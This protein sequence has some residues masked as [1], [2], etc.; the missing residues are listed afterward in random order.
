MKCRK[1]AIKDWDKL[2]DEISN[3]TPSCLLRDGYKHITS[4]INSLDQSDYNAYSAFKALDD[5]L[6]TAHYCFIQGCRSDHPMEKN[7]RESQYAM[8]SHN[9]KSAVVWY[10]SARDYCLQ[11][12]FWGF[13]FNSTI[14]S[15]KKFDSEL[16][17]CFLSGNGDD[18][19]FMKD[20]HKLAKGDSEAKEVY[21]SFNKNIRSGD[22][23][24]IIMKLCNNIKHHWGF[25]VSESYN[26]PRSV[27]V[28]KFNTNELSIETFKNEYH[29]VY[30]PPSK[31]VIPYKDLVTALANVHMK[32]IG[33]QELL[34]QKLGFQNMIDGTRKP[35]FTA[36]KSNVTR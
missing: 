12:I 11:V 20:F 15:D 7:D 13:E 31:K 1:Y 19:Q 32:L 25:E 24:D 36:K 2:Y 21:D 4:L 16:K 26:D 17:T 22:D 34:F 8:N 18:S 10:N 27:S 28:L 35:S 9:L 23:I 29:T 14:N 5:I 30:F 3:L 33:F 6:T